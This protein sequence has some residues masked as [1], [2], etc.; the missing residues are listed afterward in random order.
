L[1]E[2][3]IYGGIHYPNP[4]PTAQPFATVRTVPLDV[5]TCSK[6]SREILSLPMYPEMT[7]EQVAAV[8]AAIE[9]F[10]RET[11]HA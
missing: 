1:A 10:S 3:Q 5:P 11:E 8:A 2:R 9:E 7:R 6:L 4:L